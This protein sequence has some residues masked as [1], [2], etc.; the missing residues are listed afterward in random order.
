MG[1]GMLYIRIKSHT[2]THTNPPIMKITNSYQILETITSETD[3]YASEHWANVWNGVSHI[4]R[5]RSERVQKNHTEFIAGYV[6]RDHSGRIRLIREY[7]ADGL[8]FIQEATD[9][10]MIS[11]APFQMV[12]IERDPAGECDLMVFVDV[13]FRKDEKTRKILREH[14]EFLRLS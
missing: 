4:D 2:K 1:S 10:S 6:V 5:L 13:Y 11:S 7:F 12:N 8:R 9:Y 3:Y 14:S